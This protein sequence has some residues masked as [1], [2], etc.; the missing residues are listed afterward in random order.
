MFSPFVDSSLSEAE[1]ENHLQEK[2]GKKGDKWFE[3]K[4][5]QLHLSLATG[6]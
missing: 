4:C 1:L 5:E 6:K 3:T 2:Y